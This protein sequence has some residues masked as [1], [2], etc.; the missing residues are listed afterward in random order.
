[1]TPIYDLTP[2]ARCGHAAALHQVG[3][4]CGAAGCYCREFL[5][6]HEDELTD[7]ETGNRLGVEGGVAYALGT[8]WDAA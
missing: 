4:V 7:R 8:D 1:M 2:C 5:V 6:T 3:S